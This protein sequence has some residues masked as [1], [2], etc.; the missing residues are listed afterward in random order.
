[1]PNPFRVSYSCFFITLGLS[2]RSNP[3]LKLANAF[4]VGNSKLFL[5]KL[6]GDD[7]L[8]DLGCAFVDAQRADVAI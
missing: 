7:K 6:A 5:Q 1:M 3:G 4:G 2:L 8:L